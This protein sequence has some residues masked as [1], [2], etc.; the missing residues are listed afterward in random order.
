M[1]VTH[2][3]RAYIFENEAVKNVLFVPDFKFNLLSVSKIKRELSCRVS[4]Y[5]EFVYFRTFSVAG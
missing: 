3:G 4:F 5:L 2:I 1:E